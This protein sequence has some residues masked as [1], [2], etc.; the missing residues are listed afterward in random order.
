MHA[1][2]RTLGSAAC[3]PAVAGCLPATLFR[4]SETPRPKSIS[5]SCRDEQAGSLCSPE[6][7]VNASRR[8]TPTTP[9]RVPFLRVPPDG[10]HLH[11][12]ALPRRQLSQSRT[13]VQRL[14]PLARATT[15]SAVREKQIS[16]RLGARDRSRKF[17]RRVPALCNEHPKFLEN[18]A[19]A[20]TPMLLRRQTQVSITG[21]A[22][23]L[24]ASPA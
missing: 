12:L 14:P 19:S 10:Q 11:F 20:S 1:C 2:S 8:C 3:S 6:I 16:R 17:D 4:G 23:S 13:S 21:S 22:V 9:D 7:R 15:F 18:V 24:S 5:A